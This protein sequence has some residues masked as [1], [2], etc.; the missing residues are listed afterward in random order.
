MNDP[1]FKRRKTMLYQMNYW[2]FLVFSVI[3]VLISLSVLSAVIIQLYKETQ[4]E[5]HYVEKKLIHISKSKT[6]DWHEAIEDQLY[7]KHPD[8][9]IHVET[10]AHQSIYST[11]SESITDNNRYLI[12]LSL[13]S[14]ISFKKKFIPIYHHRFYSNGYHFDLF[15]RMIR[16]YQFIKLVAKI[17]S[18]CGV[19]GIL[20][21]LLAIYQ[22]SRHLSLPLRNVT[23][24]IKQVTASQDLKKSI[25]VPNQP[26]EVH[27]MALAFNRMMEQLDQLIDREKRFVADAS[28]ELRTPL[29]AIRGHVELIKRHGKGHPEVIEQ[30]IQFMDQESRRMQRLMDQLLMITHLEKKAAEVQTI[31]LSVIVQTVVSDYFQTTDRPIETSIAK[32]VSAL[33]NE[34]YIHQ[35]LISLLDNARKY[36]PASGSIQVAVTTDD[37]FAYIRVTNDGPVIPDAEKEAI[38]TRFYRLDKAR[39]SGKGGSGLGLSIVKTMVDMINGKIWVEDAPTGGNVFI[40][41]MKRAIE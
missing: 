2:Y 15:V 19:I 26:Q 39:N 16:I 38:F 28:H 35:I 4:Q 21:G 1:I 12:H 11:G 32:H 13:F 34:D 25:I 40:V 33:S 29:A 14:S 8:F 27:D 18:I 24:R 41:Q 37:A 10:P 23:R 36:T 20:I 17:L 30:S 5:A 3:V 31:D 7:T 9:Y 6:P 22:L